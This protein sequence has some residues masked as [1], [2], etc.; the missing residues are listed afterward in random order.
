MITKT[1]RKTDKERYK[2][3][4]QKVICSIARSLMKG[5]PCVLTAHDGQPLTFCQQHRTIN[6]VIN[7]RKIKRRTLRQGSIQVNTSLSCIH[8]SNPL[9]YFIYMYSV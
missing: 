6:E 3:G 5:V 7:C 4:R 1:K 2:Q 9:G 8:L